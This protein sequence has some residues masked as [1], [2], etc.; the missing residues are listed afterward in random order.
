MADI[1]LKSGTNAGTI[2]YRMRELVPLSRKEG[3]PVYTARVITGE[4]KQLDDVAEAMCDLN[5]LLKPAQVRM[6]LD[7]MANAVAALI[8]AGE[9]VNLGGLITLKPAIKGRWDTDTPDNV[10]TTG[11]IVVRATA[12]ARIR[13]VAESCPVTRLGDQTLPTLEEVVDLQSGTSGTLTSEGTFMVKGTKLV[14]DNEAEEEGFFL[15]LA[16]ARTKCEHL[17][18]RDGNKTVV[19]R[20]TQVMSPG[21]EP[22]LWFYTRLGTTNALYQVKLEGELIC[23]ATE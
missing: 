2:K 16:G 13:T 9:A 23:A 21:D 10:A 17:I 19:L 8:A 12:G 20:A 5:G 14:W 3:A 1:Q 15:D 4:A 22:E 18:T 7:E 6:V 11:E